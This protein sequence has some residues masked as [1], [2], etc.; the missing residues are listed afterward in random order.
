MSRSNWVHFLIF[1]NIDVFNSPYMHYITNLIWYLGYVRLLV[2]ITFAAI[3]FGV[4][5]HHTKNNML[6]LNSKL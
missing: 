6:R 5:D 1:I 4:F 2:F 3:V